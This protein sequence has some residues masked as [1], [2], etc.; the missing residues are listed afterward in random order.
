MKSPVN[1]GLRENI[2]SRRRRKPSCLSLKESNFKYAFGD[3]ASKIAVPELRILRKAGNQG[4]ILNLDHGV[5][6]GAPEDN[7][8]FF[9]ETA[10]QAVAESWGQPIDENSWSSYVLSL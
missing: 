10:K 2:R 3:D 8:R 5:L 9:F 1:W 4:H 7:V 6:V